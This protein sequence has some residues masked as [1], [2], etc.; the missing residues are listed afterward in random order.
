MIFKCFLD[1][2]KYA[3]LL[4]REVTNYISDNESKGF[5][6][7]SKQVDVTSGFAIGEGYH[8]DAIV[9]SVWMEKP[10]NKKGDGCEDGI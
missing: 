6:V 5:R 8:S 9:I 10:A 4:S 7:V 3:G 2:S 1:K